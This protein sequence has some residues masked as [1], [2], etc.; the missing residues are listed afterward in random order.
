MTALRSL[1]ACYLATA[2]VFGVA[3]ALSCHPVAAAQVKVDAQAVGAWSVVVGHRLND[4]VGKPLVAL[5]VRE[6]KALFDAIDPPLRVARAKI[7]D[8]RVAMTPKLRPAIAQLTQ[9]WIRP[10]PEPMTPPPMPRLVAAPMPDVAPPQI[11]ITPTVQYAL[12]PPPAFVP[13]PQGSSDLI[14]VTQRLKQ[15]LTPE[16]L[17]NFELFLYVSKAG[18]GP[19]AQRMYVFKKEKNGDLSLAYD[20]PVSTGRERPEITPLGRHT[21]TATP[22]GYYELDP[23]RMYARYHSHTWNES[24]PY[25]MFFNW[26]QRGY[27][28]GLAIHAAVGDDVGRLGS[29][30]SAGCVHLSLDNART[31]FALIKTDYRGLAPR[32]AY[33]RRTATMSNQGV[34]MHDATGQVKMAEGY[35]VLVF[36]EDFGGQNVVAALF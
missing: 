4:M 35:K 6:D 15:S 12:A 19:L 26:E 3:A 22:R 13:V 34:L 17:A 29:R 21:I 31:L 2:S 36:I 1:S 10:K 24:M 9:D 14:T 5:A 7:A 18:S 8:V 25:T 11:V 33:D 16:M 30:A 32:F 27:Q 20:W 28:T 23:Q